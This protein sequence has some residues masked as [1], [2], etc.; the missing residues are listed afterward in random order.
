M[1]SQT[2]VKNFQKHRTFLSKEIK[3]DHSPYTD[4]METG[5]MCSHIRELGTRQVGNFQEAP[6]EQMKEGKHLRI[7]AKNILGQDTSKSERDKYVVV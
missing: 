7:W 5:M 6:A 2:R 1:Y 3:D 4:T